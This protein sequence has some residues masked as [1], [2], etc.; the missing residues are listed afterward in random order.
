MQI[1]TLVLGPFQTNC[2]I[3]RPSENTTDCLIIDTGLSSDNLI[4]H[5]TQNNLNPIA[6]ILTHGHADHTAAIPALLKK[7]PKLEVYI[8]ELDAELLTDPQTNLSTMA[9]ITLNLQ[10]PDHTL[11][12]NQTLNIAGIQLNVIHTPGHTPGGIS[13]YCPEQNILF[14]GDT[15]FE[16]SIGRTDFPGSSFDDLI[17]AVKTKLFTLPDNTVVYP[18]H[19]PATTIAQEKKFNPFLK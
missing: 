18:G 11:T 4:D 19:G 6:I 10:P 17:N 2:Y 12:H 14:S 5:L 16:S 7:F 1:Q 13:L 8:H 15:L 3:L 9:G